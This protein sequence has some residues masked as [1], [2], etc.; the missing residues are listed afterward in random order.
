MSI[1]CYKGVVHMRDYTDKAIIIFL[2]ANI[3]V[4]VANI[5]IVVK[6]GKKNGVAK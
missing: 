6:L 5:F 2:I 4:T 3:V 1:F